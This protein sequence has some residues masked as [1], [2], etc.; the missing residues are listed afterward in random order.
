MTSRERFTVE[1]AYVAALRLEQEA[2]DSR[3]HSDY[4][5]RWD[6]DDCPRKRQLYQQP[7]VATPPLFAVL[8]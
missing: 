3:R 2:T 7:I 1:E 6:G 5:A 8:P 4:M